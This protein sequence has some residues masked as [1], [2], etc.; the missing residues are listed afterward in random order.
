MIFSSELLI[1]ANTTM[2][3]PARKLFDI[4]SGVIN[5][6]WVRWRY[7]S[8]GLCGVRVKYAEFQMFPYSIGEWLRSNR[9]AITWEER[10]AVDNA[11]FELA[12]EA[13]NLD[14]TFDHRVFV[15]VNILRINVSESATALAKE[16]LR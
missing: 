7:G 6:V 2:G 9:E 16:L 10:Y 1:P 8:G 5:Q 13:Y 14:D 4:T 12:I 15:A 3:D 11:P